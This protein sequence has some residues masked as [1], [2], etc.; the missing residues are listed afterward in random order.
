MNKAYS[1]FQECITGIHQLMRIYDKL[2]QDYPI[3]RTDIDDILRMGLVNT[4]SAMDRFIHEIVRIGIIEIYQ[5]KRP[6]T[7]KWKSTRLSYENVIKLINTE[8][9]IDIPD[10]DKEIE[11]IN[12]LN[13]E[14][15]PIL[16]TLSFQQP[17]KIKDAL[18]YIWNN[19]H[20]MQTIAGSMT[21]LVGDNLNQKQSHLEQKLRLIVHRRNSIV[22]EA[23]W[24]P[25]RDCK[26]TISITEVNDA[27]SFVEDFVS[28][29]YSNVCII[30]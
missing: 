13:R 11:V 18:S 9:R 26:Q 6:Q 24:D 25:G 19:E 17:E 28:A 3:L 29:I 12:I 22:H 23:D 20:K 1:T 5:D 7:S 4:I 16:N 27:I 14:F 2:Y 21:N 30:A 15:K 10:F 8:K